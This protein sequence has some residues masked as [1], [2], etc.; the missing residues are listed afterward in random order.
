[1]REGGYRR[2]NLS[3]FQHYIAYVIQDDVLLIVAICH[4]RQKPGFWLDRLP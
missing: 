3:I 1:L 4:S 2:V